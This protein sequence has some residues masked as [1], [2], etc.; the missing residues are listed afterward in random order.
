[1]REK[2]DR[3][4][5]AVRAKE[6]GMVATVAKKAAA[7]APRKKGSQTMAIGERTRE[8]RILADGQGGCGE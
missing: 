6:G 7:A 5:A 2:R 1:M 3:Q 4:S 8:R